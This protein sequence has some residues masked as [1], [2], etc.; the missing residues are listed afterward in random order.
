MFS[1]T[2]VPFTTKDLLVT[3]VAL[4]EHICF[5]KLEQ[6]QTIM[7][8][9]FQSIAIMPSSNSEGSLETP[10]H[11]PDQEPCRLLTDTLVIADPT[12]PGFG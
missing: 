6:I 10:P 3:K 2:I 9:T 7:I 1:T 5:L 4:S 8:V 12:R 11:A